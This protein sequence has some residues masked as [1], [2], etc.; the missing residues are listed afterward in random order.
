MIY[1]IT[2]NDFGKSMLETLEKLEAECRIKLSKYQKLILSEVATVEQTL[3]IIIGTPITIELVK[4][5]EIHHQHLNHSTTPI[6]RREVWLKDA[7]GKRLIHAVSKY[8]PRNLPGNIEADMRKGLIGIGTSIAKNELPT[9]RKVIEIGYN[10]N[11]NT[12]HREYRI[13]GK[14]NTLFEIFEEFN[15]NLFK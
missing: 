11:S 3:S 7:E 6:M 5:E 9:C 12:L 8:C 10:Q 4:Q 15:A 13:I 14:Q 2:V 1:R